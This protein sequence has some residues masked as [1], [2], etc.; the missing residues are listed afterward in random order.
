MREVEGEREH[1]GVSAGRRWKGMEE[2]VE[3]SRFARNIIGALPLIRLGQLLGFS[4][5]CSYLVH[6]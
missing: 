4:I 1:V 3:E 2:E 6:F 5:R